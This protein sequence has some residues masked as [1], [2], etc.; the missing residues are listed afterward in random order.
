V[1]TTRLVDGFILATWGVQTGHGHTHAPG[2]S[3]VYQIPLSASMVDTAST[4]ATGTEYVA[5]A[6]PVVALNARISVRPAP[7]SVTQ[8][9]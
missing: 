4:P 6:A 1:N 5:M 2:G 8:E 7:P 3:A 9:A